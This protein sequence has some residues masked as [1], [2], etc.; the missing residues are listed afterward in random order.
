[1]AARISTSTN[2]TTANSTDSSAQNSAEPHTASSSVPVQLGFLRTAR[3][4][5]I[6]SETAV[7]AAMGSS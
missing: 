7:L 2:V 6:M 1:M 3:P 4:C 5:R